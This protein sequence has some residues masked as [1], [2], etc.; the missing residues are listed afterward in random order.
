MYNPYY[1]YWYKGC[2][3]PNAYAIV[4]NLGGVPGVIV[5]KCSEEKFDFLEDLAASAN[6]LIF[7]TLDSMSHIPFNILDMDFVEDSLIGKIIE[8]NESE[9]AGIGLMS[10][11]SAS[12]EELSSV[13][14][15][16]PKTK[17][18]R[19]GSNEKLMPQTQTKRIHVQA[20]VV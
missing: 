20:A 4:R 1:L 6:Q 9:Q 14:V 5:A 15:T 16:T 12:V 17:E 11:R 18:V 7:E 19:S 13:E 10:M 3:T 2:C 8:L